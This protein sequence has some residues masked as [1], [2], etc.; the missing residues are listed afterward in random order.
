MS[1]LMLLIV[2]RMVSFVEWSSS[3]RPCPLIRTF[4][5]SLATGTSDPAGGERPASCMAKRRPEPPT[6]SEQRLGSEEQTPASQF[7]LGWESTARGMT[8][9]SFA[10][11]EGR[12]EAGG[13]RAMAQDC[14]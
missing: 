12:S 8:T 6:V 1:A 5:Y 9:I 3:A 11:S 14:A 4:S 2:L 13:R 10:W 7:A